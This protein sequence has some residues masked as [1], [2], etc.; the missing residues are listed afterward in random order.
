MMRSPRSPS[1]DH[2][3]G[4]TLIEL[5]VVI[6][7]IAIL[8]A[9]LLPVLGKAKQ[10]GKKAACLNNLHELGI[11]LQM[12][13][14]DNNGWIP[15]ANDPLWY[16][17]LSTPISRG[18]NGF[19]GTK[20]FA[21]PSYPDVRQLVG[22]VV[23]GWKFASATD[24]YGDE[25]TGMSKL[26][27]IRRPSD[28]IYLAD[29]ADGSWRPIITD[30]G[31]IGSTEVQDV[32]SVDHLPYSFASDPPKLNAQPR[33][34]PTRHGRGPNVMYFAGNAEIRRAVSITIEDWRTLHY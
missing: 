4:F 11:G 6:A 12:Y 8:A 21:C 1:P 30:T 2:A 17:V 14:E 31:I 9:M 27:A 32:W 25:L 7:I 23:N 28:T 18:T 19:I 16:E 13:A 3:S 5:L 24:P 29:D 10:S 33:V 15:R 26:S 20:V 34:A 22:Y